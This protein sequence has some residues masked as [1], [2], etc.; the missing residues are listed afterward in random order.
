MNHKFRYSILLSFF[1]SAFSY[2]QTVINYTENISVS[3]GLSSNLIRDIFQDNRGFLWI[4]TSYGVNRYDGNDI[5]QFLSNNTARSLPDNSVYNILQTDSNHLIMSTDHGIALLDLRNFSFRTIRLS[6]SGQHS[7]YDDQVILISDDFQNNIWACT[8]TLIYRLDRNLHILNTFRTQKNP[9]SSRKHNVFKL[10]PLP[11]GDVLF[12]LYNGIVKWSS[13]GDKLEPV[14]SKGNPEFRFLEG[15]SFFNTGLVS[16]RYLLRLYQNKLVVRDVTENRI[17]ELPVV[18]ND[19]FH[20]TTICNTWNN[21]IA[22][23]TDKNGIVIYKIVVEENKP[24]LKRESVWLMKNYSIKDIFQDSENNLWLVTSTRGLIKVAVSKQLFYQKNLSDPK[25]NNTAATEISSFFPINGKLWIGTF[26]DGYFQYD[27]KTGD[28][29]QY[30]AGVEPGS[31]NMVWDFRMVSDDTVWIATQQGLIW[32][33]P[34]NHHT[35]RLPQKHP[36]ILDSVA[37]TTMYEDTRGWIWMGLGRGNGLAVYDKKNAQF[38]IYP[39]QPGGYPYRYPKGAAEDANGNVWFISDV[40]GNLVRWDHTTSEFRKVIVP[41]IQGN[42]HFQSGGFYLDKSRNEIWYGVQS[43]GLVRYS[44]GDQSVKIYN[45]QSGLNSGSIMGITSDGNGRLWLNT[46]QGITSFEPA[47][48]RVVNYNKSDGLPATYFSSTI[49]FDPE[50]NRIFSG[51]P[52]V[53]T[54]F[55]APVPRIH[56]TPLRLYLTD[57]L[58][59]DQNQT[60]PENKNLL[61]G[62][63]QNNLFI[64]FSGINLS[65]GNDNIYQYRLNKGNWNNLGHRSEIRFA[66]LNPGYY[67]LN[68]RGARKGEPFGPAQTILRFTIQSPFT[69]T[70]WFYLLCFGAAVGLLYAWYRYRLYNLRKINKMRSAISMDL[71]DEIGAKLTNINMMSQIVRKNN[72]SENEDKLLKK[73]QEES[74]EISQAMREIIWNI[75][76]RND[77]LESAMPRMLT[78]ASRILE[79]HHIDLEAEINGLEGVQLNMEQRRDLFLIFKEAVHN[80]LKHSGADKVVISTRKDGKYCQLQ[81]IDNG[82][83][84]AKQTNQDINGLRYMQQRAEKHRWDF[85]IQS[86]HNI[87]T[88]ISITITTG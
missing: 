56:D 36:G 58:V 1:I 65:N 80:I 38:R 75:D 28:L 32:C 16:N 84:F 57:I 53:F 62:S 45:V 68:I 30:S 15:S 46:S 41:G 77:S 66:S 33:T 23:N 71:H 13:G 34:A 72:L 43:I 11:N 35:G 81:I 39:N 76:P 69:S 59:N 31:E 42:I 20:L 86:N 60:I 14:T 5:V 74:E 64:K 70:I 17:Y 79:P 88:C 27:F 47:S 61:L 54:W 12:W 6:P 26:G 25:R 87:G 51:A 8:P 3:N 7:E 82:K 49:Y 19:S 21:K 9:Q 55:S 52:G 4:A 37:I 48:G 29:N 24:E 63:R 40:T 85:R 2:G 50:H 44:I 10:M 78:F 22:F 67:L 83:G 18:Q 73:I